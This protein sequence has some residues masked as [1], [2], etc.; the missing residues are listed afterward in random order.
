MANATTIQ[1][2][3]ENFS[4]LKYVNS[5]SDDL[6]IKVFQYL[7][8]YSILRCERSCHYFCRVTSNNPACFT[9]FKYSFCPQNRSYMFRHYQRLNGINDPF[10]RFRHSTKVHL[11]FW[12][13]E[14]YEFRL[15]TAFGDRFRNV[16]SLTIEVNR[17]SPLVDLSQLVKKYS[18]FFV[19]IRSVIICVHGLGQPHP[20]P[21]NR[22]ITLYKSL[23]S[24]I[25]IRCSFIR[26]LTLNYSL[27][28]QCYRH[29]SSCLELTQI[30]CI[31]SKSQL[32]SDHNKIQNDDYSNIIIFKMNNSVNDIV[33]DLHFQQQQQQQQHVRN[34]NTGNDNEDSNE[35]KMKIIK[36]GNIE[37]QIQ[38]EIKIIFYRR[39]VRYSFLSYFHNHIRSIH[40]HNSMGFS[41]DIES[42][43]SR[44][45]ALDT[46]F[47]E[48]E[49][50]E[51]VCLYNVSNKITVF[52]NEHCRNCPM[53]NRMNLIFDSNKNV[54]S[55]DQLNRTIKTLLFVSCSSAATAINGVSTA[56]AIRTLEDE[57]QSVD[58][59]L[60]DY[61][62]ERDDGEDD[63][64]KTESNSQS[65]NNDLMLFTT[66][67]GSYNHRRRGLIPKL[68]RKYLNIITLNC[69][70]SNNVKLLT[71]LEK[72]FVSI[73]NEFGIDSD[74]DINSLLSQLKLF[75]HVHIDVEC[76]NVDEIKKILQLLKHKYFQSDFTSYHVIA[77]KTARSKSSTDII[78]SRFSFNTSTSSLNNSPMPDGGGQNMNERGDENESK[79]MEESM[80]STPQTANH[81]DDAEESKSNQGGNNNKDELLSPSILHRM[82][83]VGIGE[84][85]NDDGNKSDGGNNS[86]SGNLAGNFKEA[87]SKIKV[88]GNRM[89]KLIKSNSESSSNSANGSHAV[90]DS[91]ANE[92]SPKSLIS[93]ANVF[94][95][96]R[97]S[98]HRNQHQ[99]QN[100][101]LRFMKKAQIHCDDVRWI[102][103]CKY[104]QCSRKYRTLYNEND[105]NDKR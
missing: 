76:N 5:V 20:N 62:I 52:L 66:H 90:N 37:T 85:D 71:N 8:L 93:A 84:I 2:I 97:N 89:Q 38:R 73:A 22:M 11:A 7:D 105:D 82:T 3:S 16:R 32:F 100:Q 53:L 87:M 40:V 69:D 21:H 51:E 81:S 79:Q 60:E 59:G 48:Y 65:M 61:D 54:Y 35:N 78:K 102:H 67:N 33:N 10:Y 1:Q 91:N 36:L 72:S 68:M 30:L 95:G 86:S 44:R 75:V 96:R 45:L 4:S 15:L 58:Q 34:G 55:A 24:F 18:N 63:D 14:N 19:S 39:H 31:N 41:N 92:S 56:T 83:G 57:E 94:R 70:I 101:I 46:S 27:L 23:I 28:T 98:D 17:E 26:T 88:F 12:S 25:L 43:E 13:K 29:V 50:L 49:F 77:R 103:D 80:T 6:W 64:E 74:N 99:S 9:N 104:A 42:P 47:G